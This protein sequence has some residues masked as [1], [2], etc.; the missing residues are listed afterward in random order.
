M[1]LRIVAGL[2]SAGLVVAMLPGVA[3]SATAT[4]RVDGACFDNSH[5]DPI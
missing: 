4:Y 3:L 1:K 5:P 2:L